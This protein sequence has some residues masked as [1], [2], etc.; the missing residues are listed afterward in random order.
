MNQKA[1]VTTNL[2]SLRD[3]NIYFK[4][5]LLDITRN[6]RLGLKIHI[7]R[8]CGIFWP[9]MMPLSFRISIHRCWEYFCWIKRPFWK[10][11][12]VNIMHMKLRAFSFLTP[13]QIWAIILP[14][15]CLSPT[16]HRFLKLLWKLDRERHSSCKDATFRISL[17]YP[18]NLEWKIGPRFHGT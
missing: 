15:C 13:C 10:C 18:S 1:K 5:T 7:V 11:V 12:E 9:V 14:T 3:V 17:F 6:F 16:P 4:T 2:S 8:P